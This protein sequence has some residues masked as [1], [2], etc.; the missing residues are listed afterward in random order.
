[1]IR[2]EAHL[3]EYAEVVRIVT[4]AFSGVRS[5]AVQ[6]GHFMLYYD[7]V[8][9]VL[10]PCLASQL[11]GP[12][13]GPLRRAMGHFP[14]LTWTLGLRLLDAMNA[15]DRWAVVLVNDWQYCPPD[16][17]RTRF[18]EGFR[19]LPEEYERQLDDRTGR[20]RLLAPRGTH[21]GP[22][23]GPFFSEQVLRNEYKRHLKRLIDNGQLPPEVRL[24]H[25]EA[26]V[27]CSIDD[28]LGRRER[29]YCSN[30]GVNCTAE[31]AELLYQVRTLTNCDAFLNIFPS[32]CK[33]FVKAGT[34]L[35]A[36]LF[37]A[38]PRVVANMAVPST[39]LESESDIWSR[40]ALLTIHSLD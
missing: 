33:E 5:V 35:S 20:V 19:A 7:T 39:D 22:S 26:A 3:T 11:T 23:T 12:R 21:P 8:E 6:A 31:V 15:V 29:I 36:K 38:R 9:D 27:S 16:V 40:G 13:H 18:Y 34:E 10:L 2:S 4:R 30:R 28:L 14:H 32:A 24:E 1:M 25:D 37:E 17:D